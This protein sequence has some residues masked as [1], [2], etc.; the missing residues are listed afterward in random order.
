MAVA[1]NPELSPNLP[2][3][4]A[5]ER[6]WCKPT[7]HPR[8][9]APGERVPGSGVIAPKFPWTWLPSS[10]SPGDASRVGVRGRSEGELE[11]LPRQAFPSDG[12]GG[13]GAAE[14]NSPPRAP[15]PSV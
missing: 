8:L 10:A 9:A 7:S 13:R 3:R 2:L 12:G 15:A 5:A 6:E 14:P 4:P 1:D 11:P